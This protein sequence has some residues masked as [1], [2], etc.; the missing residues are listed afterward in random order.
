[1]KLLGS[2]WRLS[3]SYSQEIVHEE[4]AMTK[5]TTSSDHNSCDITK[6]NKEVDKDSDSGLYF[7]QEQSTIASGTD[8]LVA[9]PHRTQDM[10]LTPAVPLFVNETSLGRDSETGNA[11]LEKNHHEEYEKNQEVVTTAEV[12]WEIHAKSPERKY[13]QSC[14]PKR[15]RDDFTEG[16]ISADKSK[17]CMSFG[18]PM[19]RDNSQDPKEDLKTWSDRQRLSVEDLFMKRKLWTEDEELT[20]S[21]QIDDIIQVRC[22]SAPASPDV[23]NH[24]DD[25]PTVA[26]QLVTTMA[27]VTSRL[28]LLDNDTILRSSLILPHAHIGLFH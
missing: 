6:A 20:R 23:G 21:R 26:K 7:S 13:R 1:L 12:L 4:Q 28:V 15:P 16:K 18:T 3:T 5:L 17:A 11:V 24:G 8:V 9:N 2:N 10:R 14:I 27:T 19:S 25:E 22:S